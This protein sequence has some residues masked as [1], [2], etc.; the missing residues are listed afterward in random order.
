M[1][2]PCWY[3]YHI[4]CFDLLFLAFNL[5]GANA[6]GEGENLVPGMHLM[7]R[8][9]LIGRSNGIESYSMCNTHLLPDISTHGNS[10]Q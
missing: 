6:R 3:N 4:A 10:H 9:E 8:L 1:L 2:C 5:C 7:H